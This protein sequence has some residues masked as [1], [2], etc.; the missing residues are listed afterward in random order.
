MIYSSSI[1]PNQGLEILSLTPEQLDTTQGFLVDTA[2][3]FALKELEPLSM[4]WLKALKMK[5]MKNVYRSS[6]VFIP[7]IHSEVWTLQIFLFLS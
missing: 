7:V 4:N 6:R 1:E 3:D 2:Q 5:K